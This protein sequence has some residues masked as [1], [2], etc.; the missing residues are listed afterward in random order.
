VKWSAPTV[1]TLLTSRALV[2]EY[3]PY[4]STGRGRKPRGEPVPGYYPALIAEREFQSVQAALKTRS[5]IGRGRAGKHVN[6]LAGLLRDAS[7]ERTMTYRHPNTRRAIVVAIGSGPHVAYPAIDLETAILSR[8]VEV[9][10][11]DVE[12]TGTDATKKVADLSS[13][14][15]GVEALMAAWSAKMDDVN[16]VDRVAAKLGELE[17]QRRKLTEEM[18]AA[19]R[20]AAGPV[21]EAVGGMTTL[22]ELMRNDSSDGMRVKVRAAVRRVVERIDLLVVRLDKLGRRKAVAAQ[23]HFGRG[24]LR[25]YAIRPAADGE[26]YEVE[27]G[28]RETDQVYDLSTAEGWAAVEARLRGPSWSQ[29][30]SP[31]DG[32]GIVRMLPAPQAALRRNLKGARLARTRRR[33]VGG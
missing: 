2:G 31:P 17:A 3:V 32:A 20:E 4:T 25:M 30:V 9:T 10:A 15:K 11:A 29:M 13:E 23:V 27:S 28:P 24:R 14:L 16:I 21:A 7:T 5:R 12:G 33:T 22:I 18:A 26:G 8:L 6:I 19:Q 1:Y